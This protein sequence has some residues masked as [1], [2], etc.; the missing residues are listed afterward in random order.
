MPISFEF[1]TSPLQQS[2]Y[3]LGQQKD[4]S[5]TAADP[6]TT[7]VIDTPK[8]SNLD[9]ETV[10]FENFGNVYALYR[11]MGH[12]P[13]VAGFLA[14]ACHFSSKEKASICQFLKGHAATDA[15]KQVLT[16]MESPV[17]RNIAKQHLVGF[18]ALGE[19][20]YGSVPSDNWEKLFTE[21]KGFTWVE[22]V[23][24]LKNLD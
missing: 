6:T 17:L 2:F 7:A 10:V 11:G 18:R 15:G 20:P 4:S 8:M 1:P 3:V 9:L 5:T 21:L 23:K 16:V 19:R 14:L 13:V 22:A 12:C 24:Q